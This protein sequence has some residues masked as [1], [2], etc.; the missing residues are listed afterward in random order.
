MKIDQNI[1]DAIKALIAIIIVVVLIVVGI[2]VYDAVTNPEAEEIYGFIT[3]ALILHD[4][5]DEDEVK[6]NILGLV[7]DISGNPTEKSEDIDLVLISK[8]R[9][10]RAYKERFGILVSPTYEMRALKESLIEEGRLFLNSYSY[11]REALESKV[12]NDYNAFL[13][14]TEKAIQ[15]LDDA[16]NLRAQNRVEL[17]LWEMKIETELSN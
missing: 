11:L 3:F 2:G 16:I 1:K 8:S 17:S 10:M 12:N 14:N 15:Y 4:D 7:D 9:V 6:D 5:L 13:S